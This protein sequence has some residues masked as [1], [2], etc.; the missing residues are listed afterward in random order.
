MS[1]ELTIKATN[2]EPDFKTNKSDVVASLVKLAGNLAS[3]LAAAGLM[4]PAASAQTRLLAEIISIRIPNQKQERVINFLRTL[5]DRVK[6][7]EEDVAKKLDTEE[8]ADLLEDGLH[9]AS[10]ALTDER[11]VYIANLLT[12][13]LTDDS[14][15]HLAQ[16]K[17]LSILNELN[18]AEV[19]LLHYYGSRQ[20]DT[21]LADEIMRKHAF[22]K[23]AISSYPSVQPEIEEE[24][25]YHDYKGKLVITSL[26]FGVGGDGERPTALGNLLLR[27]VKPEQS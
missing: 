5:G 18:D 6:Y 16:K 24:I 19:I 13:S 2:E 25:M 9:Q 23:I 20:T 27:Y 17:L 26:V 15:D 7:L 11:K 21:N 1:T 8:F 12:T 4:D 14:L 3:V 22:I 10:R